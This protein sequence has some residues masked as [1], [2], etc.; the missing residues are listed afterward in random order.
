[1]TTCWDW[2]DSTVSIT[3]QKDSQWRGSSYD[4]RY[5]YYAEAWV[6]ADADTGSWDLSSSFWLAVG[7]EYWPFDEFEYGYYYEDFLSS[8][9]SDYLTLD[10]E[11]SIS[12]G[13]VAYDGDGASFDV[14]VE[15]GSP[16]GY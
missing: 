14:T 9:S 11:I 13:Q 7:W 4:Q 10:P 15:L 8:S 16:T 1:M 3:L 5:C 12:S 6:S 2:Y